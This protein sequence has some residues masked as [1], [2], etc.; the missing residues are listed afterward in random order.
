MGKRPRA[1]HEL[2]P[3]AVMFY[4]HSLT[5]LSSMMCGLMRPRII[6]D[7]V[8]TRARQLRCLWQ[9][10]VGSQ[11]LG[12]FAW[13]ACGLYQDW[14]KNFPPKFLGQTASSS[15]SRAAHV[16]RNADMSEYVIDCSPGWG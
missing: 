7:N 5:T 6:D 8:V 15:P 16:T 13:F 10:P 11:V 9:W 4:A 14:R 3:A 2:H 1:K 12:S